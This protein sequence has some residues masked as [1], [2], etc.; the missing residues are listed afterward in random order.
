MDLSF[1]SPKGQTGKGKKTKGIESTLYEA[2]AKQK[3]SFDPPSVKKLKPGCSKEGDAVPAS[4]ILM[5]EARLNL[6]P[7]LRPCSFA[8]TMAGSLV[9]P[10]V[11]STNQRLF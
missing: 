4:T 2:R 3:R 5:G 8:H 11:F 9:C 10:I 6:Q 1:S 7:F